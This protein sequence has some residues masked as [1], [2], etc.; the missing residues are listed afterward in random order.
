MNK[1]VNTKITTTAGDEDEI[2]Y[3]P[4][5]LMINFKETIHKEFDEK[6]KCMQCFSVASDPADHPQHEDL[7]NDIKSFYDKQI[8]L[9][10]QELVG[11]KKEMKELPG[12]YNNTQV[13]EV[14]YYNFEVQGK[15]K[16][17][18]EIIDKIKELGY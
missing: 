9:L 16:Q 14:Q 4:K 11:E 6:F 3:L 8:T 17:R 1:I 10:L 12:D 15:N 5:D 13:D 7:S 2:T 18:Q